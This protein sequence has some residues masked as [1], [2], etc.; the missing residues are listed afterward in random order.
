[1]KTFITV[2]IFFVFQTLTGFTQ[3]SQ[4]LVVSDAVSRKGI[5]Y[6]TV[7]V[8]NKPDGTYADS[9][10]RF[11][12]KTKANDSLLLTCV[13]YVSIIVVYQRDTIFLD[14]VVVDLG[15]VKVRSKKSKEYAVGL[16]DSKRNETL[17]LCGN[18]NV[19]NSLMIKIPDFF[20]YYRIKGVQFNAKH[21]NGIAPVRLHIYTQGKDGMPDKELLSKDVI[22]NKYLKSNGQIDLSSLNL[23]VNDRVLFV[24][25]EDILSNT[26]FSLK[27][28][29]CI[30]FGF[31]SEEKQQLTYDRTLLDPKYHWRKSRVSWIRDSKSG[32]PAN[33]M[34]SLIID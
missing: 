14:P 7:K 4:R 13:G 22:I 16:A 2:L 25:I 5:P 11:E 9:L 29:E 32:N 28:G 18:V 20:T 26:K 21:E 27:N 3:V 17:F 23:V 24:G 34:V 31:T 10:G 6:A 15:E 12:V 8:L 19:E 33:L 30:G 1:M